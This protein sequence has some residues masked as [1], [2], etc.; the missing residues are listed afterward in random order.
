MFGVDIDIKD[1]KLYKGEHIAL[2][3]DI[4][5]NGLVQSN[6]IAS[7]RKFLLGIGERIFRMDV[8]NDKAVDIRDL[9]RIKKLIASSA[10]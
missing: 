2:A 10:E 5:G 7:V 3:G 6:D 1:A 9:I 8:N 4:D